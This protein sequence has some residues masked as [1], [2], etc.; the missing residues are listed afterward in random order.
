MKYE[1]LLERR[2]CMYIGASTRLPNKS[3]GNK[4]KLAVLYLMMGVFRFPN[5]SAENA[6]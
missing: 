5:R 1:T 3:Y 2:L 4:T 6:R